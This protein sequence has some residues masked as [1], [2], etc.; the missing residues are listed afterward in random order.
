M[1]PNSI[2]DTLKQKGMNSDFLSR[3]NLA[4]QY[5]ISNYT[6]TEDQNVALLKAISGPVATSLPTGTV[7]Q[8]ATKT[9]TTV[10]KPVTTTTTT[11][12]KPSETYDPVALAKLAGQ[13]G[14]SVNDLKTLLDQGGGTFGVDK[15]Q[16]TKD[17]GIADLESKVFTAPSKSTESLFNEAYTASGLDQVDTSIKALMDDIATRRSQLKEATD[18]INN[19]PFLSE[20]TR[21]GQGKLR[22]DQAET[23]INNKVNELNTLRQWKQ[24]QLTNINNK[25]LL[26]TTDFKNNQELNAKKLDYLTKKRDQMVTD[27][28]ST[29]KTELSGK[30]LLEYLMNQP[31]K[32][33]TNGTFWDP[34]TG[35][36]ITPTKTTT[37]VTTPKGTFV[38][39]KLTY[40]PQDQSEDSQALEASRGADGFVDP[41]TYQK[42]YQA[43]VNNGGLVKDFISKYPPKNYVNPANT[44]LP[45]YLM[46]TA[47]A[48]KK[49]T[50]TTINDL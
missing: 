14:M 34:A 24:D 40:S 49:K 46:P 44:W 7:T 29:K 17:L 1:D 13:K 23:D 48:T 36:W 22:L 33:L 16:I 45:P 10:E 39:G 25:I 8:P 4:K 43:W 41:T 15:E 2:V 37:K 38:S 12:T 20:K 19:N 18:S 27:K 35:Q 9:T 3:T 21:I 5:G 42:L 50:G 31:K 28:T 26:N 30:A 47:T 32:A 11:E 6:G